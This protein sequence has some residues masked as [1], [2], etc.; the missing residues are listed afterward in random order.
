VLI[1]EKE[2]LTHERILED[3]EIKLSST[4]RVAISNSIISLFALIV[5]VFLF[6]VVL[7]ET[8]HL[9]LLLAICGIAYLN[10][11]CVAS[12]VK[13]N[14][15]HQ[16]IK[17][18]QYRI[19]TD[20]LINKQERESYPATS[21]FMYFSKAAKLEFYAYGAFYPISDNTSHSSDRFVVSDEDNFISSSVGDTFL[22]IINQKQKVLLVYNTKVFDYNE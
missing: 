10:Y 16:D 9:L 4:R 19:V 7:E 13:R 5:S 3:Y 12:L 15:S 22:L 18:C 8:F 17:N 20:K 21:F 14:K 2:V 6:I 11:L 1:M